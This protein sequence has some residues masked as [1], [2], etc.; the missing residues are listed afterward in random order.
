MTTLVDPVSKAPRSTAHICASVPDNPQGHVS[1]VLPTGN[2]RDEAIV[3]HSDDDTETG[4]KLTEI[5]LDG[6]LASETWY[7]SPRNGGAH[8]LVLPLLSADSFYKV[9]AGGKL[10]P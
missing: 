6:G 7:A 4:C 8:S 3:I 5:E 1:I 9:D 10:I 2:T